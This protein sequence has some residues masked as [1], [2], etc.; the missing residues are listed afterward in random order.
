MDKQVA[1]IHRKKY[2]SK[3]KK[4]WTSDRWKNTVES[5]ECYLSVKKWELREGHILYSFTCIKFLNKY[6]ELQWKKA[7]HWLS[8]AATGGQ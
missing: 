3:N 1:I 7:D 6:N 4:E 8:G 2:L 5:P